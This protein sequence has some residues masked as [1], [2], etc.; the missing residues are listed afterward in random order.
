MDGS[1]LFF[2]P[3]FQNSLTSDNDQ[4][5]IDRVIVE[6]KIWVKQVKENKDGCIMYIPDNSV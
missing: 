1:F 6:R 2:P 5:L 4:I 3:K